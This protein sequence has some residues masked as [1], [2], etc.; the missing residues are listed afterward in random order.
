MVAGSGLDLH[1]SDDSRCWASPLYAY[2]PFVYI[3]F[4]CLVFMGCLL[5]VEL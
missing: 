2:W 1:L 4:F 3:Q 5:V